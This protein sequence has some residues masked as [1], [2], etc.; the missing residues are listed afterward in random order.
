MLSHHNIL[1]N[2]ESIEEIFELTGHDRMLGTLPLHHA[3]GITVTLWLPL[4]TG[5]GVIYQADPLDAQR[6]TAQM[7]M[8]KATF[9]VSTPAGYTHYLQHCPATAL[10]TLRHAISGADRL[11]PELAEAFQATYG[12]PLLEGYGCTE[13]APVI[14]VNVP[15]VLHGSRRQTGLKPGTVGHPLPGVAVKVVHPHTGAILPYGAEGAVLAQGPNCMLGYLGEP[16]LTTAVM[17]DGWFVTGDTGS[18]DE[19]GFLRITGRLSVDK[20]RHSMPVRI[21]RCLPEDSEKGGVSARYR[22]KLLPN[23]YDQ[24]EP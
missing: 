13:M 24:E 3:F 9:L 14:A 1:S 12:L 22:E 16:E 20:A 15:D 17:R 10:T 7:Q 8:H 5:F 21:R 6:L 23:T 18:M 19:D 4:I 11:S 2:L